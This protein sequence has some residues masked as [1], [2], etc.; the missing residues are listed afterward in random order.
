MVGWA[1]AHVGRLE[2]VT[3]WLEHTTSFSY[4]ANSNQTKT[5]FPKNEDIYTFNEADQLTKT[6][7]KK[8]A[9]TVA[10]L[11]YTRDSAG[12]LKATAQTGL[13]G[14]AEPKYTYDENNRLT[15]GGTIEYKYDTADNPTTTGSS[16]NTYNEGDELEKGTGV[17]Y[18]YDEL[19]ERTKRTPTT[20]PATTYGYDQAGN[21]ASV[22]RP[23]E[24]EVTAIKDSYGYDGNGLRASQTIGET[25]TYL[26]WDSSTPLPLILNDGTNSYVYGPGGLPVEQIS[27][28]GTVLYVHH[29]QQGSTRLLTSSTGAKEA[30]FTYDAYGNQTGHTGTATSPLGYDAQYTST[31]TGLIYLRARVYDPA[32]AQVLSVDPLVSVT[33]APYNYV[34]DNPLNFSDPTGLIFG[35]PGTPSWEEVGEGV[36]GWGDK[37]TFGA[38]KW[39]REE[40]GNNNINPCSSAYQAGGYGGLATALLIPGEGEVRLGAEAAAEEATGVAGWGTLL[41][42]VV[43]ATGHHYFFIGTSGLAVVGGLGGVGYLIYEKV[44]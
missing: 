17:T 22:E 11:T 16:T 3:D 32:T 9:E 41:N 6:E 2:K 28:G 40:L 26:A 25:T 23:K 10:K 19:G 21:L 39:A 38:T 14:E 8:A 44:K 1:R 30:S 7:M 33:R 31:D 34:G 12:Q 35:I 43:E 13:P 24:G 15:K 37:L 42:D 36:A 18:S 27:G 4:D 5:I 29:D 20:G